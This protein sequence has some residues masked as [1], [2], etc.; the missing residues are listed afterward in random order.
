MT[1]PSVLAA[2]AVLPRF[3]APLSRGG[4]TLLT[5]QLVT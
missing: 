4:A 3:G 1:T 2:T 5:Q